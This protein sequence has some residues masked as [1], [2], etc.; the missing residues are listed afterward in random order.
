MLGC[1]PCPVGTYEDGTHTR[2]LPCPAGTYNNGTGQYINVTL[3]SPVVGCLACPPLQV[4]SPGSSHC[5]D[6]WK[7]DPRTGQYFPD[8]GGPNTWAAANN[9]CLPCPE[10]LFINTTFVNATSVG[11]SRCAKGYYR[12]SGMIDC[13]PAPPGMYMN[14]QGNDSNNTSSRRLLRDD[15]EFAQASLRKR[16]LA[17]LVH[18][19]RR[20]LENAANDTR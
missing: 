18:N 14:D 13:V 17:Y 19:M 8:G 10:N 7:K 6:C 5:F 9:T 1:E 3:N 12:A 16:T 4:S 15:P 2:C 11:C 20:Y